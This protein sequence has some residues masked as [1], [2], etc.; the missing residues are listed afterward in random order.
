MDPQQPMAPETPTAP[1]PAPVA[2]P[3]PAPSTAAPQ[4]P[5]PNVPD[6]WPGA[7]GVYKHSK[8]AV[9][10]NLGTLILLYVIS[11]GSSIILPLLLRTPGQIIEYIISIFIGVATYAVMLAGVR[12][13]KLSLGESFKKA[14]DIMLLLKFF[15]L[16][17][18]MGLALGFSLVLFVVPFILLLPRVILAPWYMIDKNLGVGE[19]LNASWENSRGHFGKVWG[20][21]GATW[22][23]FLPFLTIIGIPFA[24]YFL[25]MYSA[26]IVVLYEY[27]NGGKASIP[28]TGPVSHGP[29]ASPAVTEQEPT[30]P[31]VAQTPPVQPP[32]PTEPTPSS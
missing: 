9:M 7:F 6:S 15:V 11:F 14:S 22:V 4:K 27:I 20:I 2:V 24:I 5:V 3:T 31:S 19:S 17:L 21:V 13:K 30:Q 29:V 28:A 16:V 25:L 12:G 32:T 18:V 10:T 23:L 8:A 26:A 1:N